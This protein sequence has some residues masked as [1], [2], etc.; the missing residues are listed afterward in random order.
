MVAKKQKSFNL[1]LDDLLAGLDLPS[2]E[3]IVEETRKAKI[4]KTTTGKQKP[5]GF[6]EK[7][8]AAKKGKKQS[9]EHRA[10][11]SAARK[12]KKLSEEHR[13]KVSASMQGRT[14]SAE[15][16]AK[17]GSANKGRKLPKQSAE[18]IAKRS[19][20]LTGRPGG[21]TGKTLSAESR[22][23][24]SK[25]NKG[26]TLSSESRAK[27]SAGK[28]GKSYGGNFKPVITPY[29][30]F[31]SLKEAGEHEE[32]I[33]GRKFNPNR[34]TNLLKDPSSGYRRISAEEYETVAKK[35]QKKKK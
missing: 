14:V 11:N 29:G 7:L 4:S 35:P 20:K 5:S 32:P 22:A 23:K 3:D 24:I 18:T 26:R 10:K 33:T 30:V 9:E 15:T 28:K 27:I 8:S 17:I 25:S 21:M 13:A 19:A 31:V 6:S 1:E 12:G 16:R 2:Q 34:F